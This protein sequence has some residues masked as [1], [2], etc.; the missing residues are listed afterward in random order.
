M[1]IPSF[2]SHYKTANLCYCIWLSPHAFAQQVLSRSGGVYFWGDS[3]DKTY[4]ASHKLGKR[5]ACLVTGVQDGV[6]HAF[7]KQCVAH[8]LRN[9]YVHL[10][11]P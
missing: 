5:R 1:I 4:H 7:V 3:S 6:E 9:D 11:L 8:P 2:D 10:V